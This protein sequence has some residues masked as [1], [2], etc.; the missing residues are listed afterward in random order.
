[1]TGTVYEGDST[2][3]GLYKKVT[4]DDADCV[5]EGERTRRRPYMTGTLYEEKVNKANST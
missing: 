4:V 2:L 5:H 1:M 3:M